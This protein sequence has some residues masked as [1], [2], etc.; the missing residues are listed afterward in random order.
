ME[1]LCTRPCTKQLCTCWARA[2]PRHQ[3]IHDERAMQQKMLT[4]TTQTVGPWAIPFVVIHGSY[5]QCRIMNAS[6]TSMIEVAS[7]QPTINQHICMQ[8]QPMV[9]AL[10]YPLLSRIMQAHLYSRCHMSHTTP[11]P[12]RTRHTRSPPVVNICPPIRKRAARSCCSLPSDAAHTAH[13]LVAA[14]AGVHALLGGPPRH[15]HH[16]QQPSA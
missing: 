7:S 2:H 13:L 4:P 6:C 10:P 3:G 12:H 8:L 9:L 1:M 16:Q 15:H 11:T 14:A 5:R